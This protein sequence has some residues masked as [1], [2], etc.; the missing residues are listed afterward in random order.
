MVNGKNRVRRDIYKIL[1]YY[2]T[3]NCCMKCTIHDDM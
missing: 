2:I 1:Q 3:V